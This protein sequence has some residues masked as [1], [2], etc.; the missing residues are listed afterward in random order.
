MV[1]LQHTARSQ[2]SPAFLTVSTA[3]SKQCSSMTVHDMK[4]ASEAPSVMPCPSR[5]MKMRIK[6]SAS[7]IY[8]LLAITL[9]TAPTVTA[10]HPDI[11]P[12]AHP[13]HSTEEDHKAHFGP[14]LHG[15]DVL[16]D[17]SQWLLFQE[18]WRVIGNHLATPNF[19][20]A[21][22]NAAG[23]IYSQYSFHGVYA[24]S[25]VS[26]A[27]P[28]FLDGQPG[29]LLTPL[30]TTC[31]SMCTPGCIELQARFCIRTCIFFV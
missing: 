27:A 3:V 23:I 12:H 10:Q 29:G 31:D 6:V 28:V 18:H 25:H 8:L 14:H 30:R 11:G 17:G 7:C 5:H 2:H 22:E 13:D 20:A 26:H 19:T 9:L 15:P 24:G 16:P 21:L 1:N 4:G